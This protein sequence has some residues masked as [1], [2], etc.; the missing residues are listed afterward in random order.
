MKSRSKTLADKSIASMLA[1]LEIYNK[2]DFKYRE[3]TFSILATTSWELLLKARLL[4]LGGNKPR[5]ILEYRKRQKCDGT[6]TAKKYKVKNRSGNYNTISLFKAFDSLVNAH[7]DTIQPIVR[8]NLEA[9]VEVRDNSVHFLNDDLR[10]SKKVHEV[11]TASIKNYTRLLYNWFGIAL[12]HYDIFMY[13]S[14]LKTD[15]CRDP[16]IV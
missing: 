10:L 13:L 14:I 12:S 11:G 2:P 16:G 1:A 3:E 8:N 5:S 15:L 7:G 9:L 6:L 4:Q